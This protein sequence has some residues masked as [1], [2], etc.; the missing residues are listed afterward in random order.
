M[1]NKYKG[2]IMKLEN[3][4]FGVG[5]ANKIRMGVKSKDGMSFKSIPQN[6]DITKRFERV[7]LD[8]LLILKKQNK[9]LCST[10]T[11]RETGEKTEYEVILKE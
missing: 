10:L 4:D 5:F 7:M 6:I 8:Y 9:I 3:I 11:N 2:E 1:N